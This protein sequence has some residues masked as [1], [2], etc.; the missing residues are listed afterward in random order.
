MAGLMDG[1]AGL[2]TG[3]ASGIGRA[4]ALRFAA[5][6]AAVVV[7]DLPEARDGGE[8]TVARIRAAG[9][10]AEFFACVVSSSSDSEALV[11]HVV[12]RFGRLDFAHNNAGIGVHRLLHDT[13]DE[14]F[15]RVIAV[16]LRGAFLCGRA[17]FRSNARRIIAIGSISGTLGTAQAA[18]YNASKWGIT[19]LM[20]SLA[21]E[22]RERNIFCATVLP[23]SVDTEMLKKTP[24][25]PQMQ[26]RDVARVVT[27]LVTQAPFAMTGSAVEVFG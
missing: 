24:F 4:C 11:A 12:A 20:K 6:G 23:G 26:P 19:G 2:V 22:G 25:Q 9:G 15:D 13:S 3:A 10:A 18:A 17:A 1:N 8:E 21:E 14:D 5:E 27:F 16:N 7:A